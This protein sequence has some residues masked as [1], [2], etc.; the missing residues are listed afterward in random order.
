MIYD[1]TGH[2]LFESSPRER[3]LYLW[4]PDATS[5]PIQVTVAAVFSRIVAIVIGGFKPKVPLIYTNYR[6]VRSLVFLV[7]DMNYVHL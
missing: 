3:Q 5:T 4:R 1:A 7:C 6:V 2:P